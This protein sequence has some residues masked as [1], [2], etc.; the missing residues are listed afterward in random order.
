[1]SKTESPEAQ[2][3]NSPQPSAEKPKK[4]E[5]VKKQRVELPPLIEMTIT[6]SRTSV[7]LITMVVAL[8]SL[9]TGAD[10]LTLFVR[11]IVAMMVSGL[12]LW[13]VSWWVTQNYF[14]SMREQSKNPE[15][16]IPDGA[17]KDIKA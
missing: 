1:M 16:G 14:D 8:I 2:K 7:V 17:M 4:K 10:L 13:L 9:S 5:K 12:L 6:F 11:S 15:E 3:L